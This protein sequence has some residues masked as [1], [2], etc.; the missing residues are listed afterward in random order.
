[1][2]S[3]R[4]FAL[5]ALLAAA[6]A[7]NAF[8]LSLTPA[9]ADFFFQMNGNVGADDVETITPGTTQLIEVYKQDVGGA[10]AGAFANSYTT[11]FAPLVSPK[12]A[13]ISYD[14]AP[15]PVIGGTEIWALAKDGETGHYL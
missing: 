13:T 9:N 15:D 2:K 4:K 1:M 6:T 3:P 7:V 8:A 12:G 11:V 5:A 10:E 14:G